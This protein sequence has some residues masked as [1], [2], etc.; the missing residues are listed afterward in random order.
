MSR[1]KSNTVTVYLFRHGII[2]WLFI[3]WWWRPIV[4]IFWLFYNAIFNVR[5]EFKKQN[6]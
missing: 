1:R 3:G 6:K 4:Y 5:V 2:W